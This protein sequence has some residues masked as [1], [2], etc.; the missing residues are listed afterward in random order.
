[1]TLSKFL[2]SDTPRLTRNGTIIPA[3]GPETVGEFYPLFSSR[4]RFFFEAKRPYIM[5][6]STYIN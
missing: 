5:N 4:L 6:H 1:M 3:A 2:L